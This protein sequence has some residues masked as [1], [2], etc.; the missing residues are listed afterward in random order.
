MLK[1][2]AGVPKDFSFHKGYF[3]PSCTGGQYVLKNIDAQSLNSVHWKD[4]NLIFKDQEKVLE[5]AGSRVVSISAS[6][7]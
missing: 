4:C 6:S 2:H 7:K 5:M 1:D 3:V